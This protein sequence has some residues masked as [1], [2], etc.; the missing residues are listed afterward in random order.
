MNRLIVIKMLV[1]VVFGLAVIGGF[2]PESVSAQE[3]DQKTT[4]QKFP[5]EVLID[6]TPRLEAYLKFRRDKVDELA[7]KY[8]K[9]LESLLGKAADAGDLKTADSFQSEKK[10]LEALKASWASKPK[11]PVA[12]VREN[13]QL[14]ELAKGTPDA[15]VSLRKIWYSE[16]GKISAKLDGALQQSL[17]TLETD[18]TKQ[19]K[20]ENAKTVMAFREALLTNRPKSVAVV[21]KKPIGVPVTSG[22]IT[23]SAIEVATKEKPFVNSLKMRFVPVKI[24]GGQTRGKTVLFSVWETRVED[25]EAF[26]RKNRDHSWPE[27]PFEQEKDCPAVMV[28]WDDAQAFCAWL[29][30]KERGAGKIG[31]KEAYRLPYDHEWSCAVGLGKMEDGD[32]TPFSKDRRITDDYPWGKTWPPNSDAGNYK[33]Q[34]SS[35]PGAKLPHNDGFERSSPVGSFKVNS[36]GL[37]DLGGNVGE[38]CQDLMNP[39][40]ANEYGVRGSTYGWGVQSALLSSRRFAVRNNSQQQVTGFRVVIVREK[41]MK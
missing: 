23:D 13:V 9:A 25:Y 17:K 2:S 15:L 10:R 12:A 29:T 34:E 18:L 22:T 3:A 6:M 35:T 4:P 24:T 26:I 27:L 8:G 11:D 41:G 20:L 32:A 7:A 5:M 33:G 19:R 37:Y 1:A 28:S 30:K 40:V 36:F 14:P 39:E 16:W 38:I 21:E 31:K